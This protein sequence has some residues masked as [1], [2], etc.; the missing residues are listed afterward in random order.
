MTKF[1]NCEMVAGHITLKLKG[2]MT[3]Y[4][5]YGY[6]YRRMM[7]EG[8]MICLQPADKRRSV[9]FMA[10]VEKVESITYEFK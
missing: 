5:I 8:D 3:D 1:T 4:K 9:V 10:P 7:E 6:A 2:G